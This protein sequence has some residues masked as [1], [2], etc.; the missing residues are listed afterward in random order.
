MQ[1]I[2]CPFDEVTVDVLQGDFSME[3]C[4]HPIAGDVY[5]LLRYF[6]A[7]WVELYDLSFRT[8]QLSLVCAKLDV[9]RMVRADIDQGKEP[10]AD[11]LVGVALVTVEVICG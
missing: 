8:R 4:R 9:W 2:A 5:Y 7:D 6:N 1:A 3:T 10:K 11:H